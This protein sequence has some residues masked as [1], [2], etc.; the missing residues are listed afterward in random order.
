MGLSLQIKI[1]LVKNGASACSIK[2]LTRTHTTAWHSGRLMKNMRCCVGSLSRPAVY[3]FWPFAQ[4]PLIVRPRLQR[5][6]RRRLRIFIHCREVTLKTQ[7]SGLI[8]PPNGFFL[9]KSPTLHIRDG[10][11]IQRKN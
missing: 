2:R 10:K 6:W 5:K 1:G 3:K 9:L 11:V 7:H 4:F 8:T